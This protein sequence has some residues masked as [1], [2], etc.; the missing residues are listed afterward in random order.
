MPQPRAFMGILNEPGNVSHNKRG[1]PVLYD[2]EIGRE[3][4][5]GVV[6]DLG[7]RG[8]DDGQKRGFPRVGV[9]HEP[10]VGDGF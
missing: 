9:P 8:G 7:P 3:G 6:G 1:L 2:A 4:R 5:E 10:H